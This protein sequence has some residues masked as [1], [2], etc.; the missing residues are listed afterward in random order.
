MS[1]KSVA[2]DIAS[3]VDY[4]VEDLHPEDRVKALDEIARQVTELAR[5]KEAWNL[6]HGVPE[7]HPSQQTSEGV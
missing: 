5:K 7:R 3:E 2:K 6:D 1:W 4:E